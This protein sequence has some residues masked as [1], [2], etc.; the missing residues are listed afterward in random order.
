MKKRNIMIGSVVLLAVLLVV[1]GTMAWFTDTADPVFNKF[2]AGTVE[3]VLHDKTLDKDEN[4]EYVLDD[5][6]EPI[7]INF[8]PNGFINVN[9]GD[10]YDKIVY[11]ENTGSKRVFV[12]I[13]LIPYWEDDLALEIEGVPMAEYPILN[14]WTLVEEPTGEFWY[15]YPEEVLPGQFT[16]PIIDKVEFAGAEMTNNYQGKLFTL[17]VRAEAIQVTNGAALDLWGVDPLTLGE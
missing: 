10:E 3:I 11:V 16:L 1:G 5:N 7:E 8:P 14:G 12:R 13:Q 4:G 17:E 15:Y 6:E 2:T 9:P